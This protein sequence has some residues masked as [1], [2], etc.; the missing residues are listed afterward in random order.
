MKIMQA[1]GLSQKEVIDSTFDEL[2][3]LFKEESIKDFEQET[4]LTPL[5]EYGK[6]KEEFYC[7]GFVFQTETSST[8]IIFTARRVVR[9]DFGIDYGLRW[10]HC[11]P[12]DS[13]EDFNP[14]D[15]ISFQNSRRWILAK[16]YQDQLLALGR[17]VPHSY[18]IPGDEGDRLYSPDIIHRLTVKI[19]ADR[20][21]RI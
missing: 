2:K 20:I 8:E 1:T 10:C 21:R 16:P 5:M 18:M 9:G 17:N 13:L 19:L 14:A 15:H 3:S 11:G 6:T 4:Y 7:S 12:I